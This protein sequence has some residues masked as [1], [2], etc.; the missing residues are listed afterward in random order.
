MG[1]TI[2]DDRQAAEPTFRLPSLNEAIDFRLE[3]FPSAD[4]RREFVDGDKI[5]MRIKGSSSRT[6]GRSVLGTEAAASVFRAAIG[7]R[8][9]WV[10]HGFSL[11]EKPRSTDLEE[12]S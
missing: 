12:S 11:R 1:D 9:A 2:A 6:P 5:S 4:Y 10:L 8:A 7:M 3:Y